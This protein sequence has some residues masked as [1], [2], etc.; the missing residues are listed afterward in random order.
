MYNIKLQIFHSTSLFMMLTNRPIYVARFMKPYHTSCSHK[1]MRRS[2]TDT[3]IHT[4]AYMCNYTCMQTHIYAHMF[5][6]ETV[7]YCSYAWCNVYMHVCMYLAYILSH[8]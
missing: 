6:R 5:A 8:A 2:L 1:I 3:H 7:T 4:C